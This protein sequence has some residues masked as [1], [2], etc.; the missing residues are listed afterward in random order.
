MT[1]IL[2]VVHGFPPRN[3]AGTETY[4]FSLARERARDYQVRVF[5][6]LADP[7][8]EEY[9]VE[10]GVYKDLAYW[11]INNT[12]RADNSFEAYYLNPELEPPFRACLDDFKP[13]LIHFTYLLG[14]LTARYIHIAKEYNL[15]IL[16]TLTDFILLCGW[17]QLL[18]RNGEICNGT[19]G[20]LNCL[21]CLWRES[22]VLKN[23]PY[24]GFSKGFYPP[25]GQQK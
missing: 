22:L 6:R 3:V 2:Y 7:E 24:P 4:T 9:S 19:N 25:H 18:D 8:K 10:K 20:G 13:D 11:A 1:K 12:Y 5:Y 15:P 17:G 16:V 21:P 23:K 14:G